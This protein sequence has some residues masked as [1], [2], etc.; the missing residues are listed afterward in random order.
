[1]L[2]YLIQDNPD[3]K[4]AI[5]EYLTENDLVFIR[6][7]INPPKKFIVCLSLKRNVNW[8]YAHFKNQ[9]N[10]S[11]NLKGRPREKSFLYDLI[12]NCHDT[13]DVDK[14]D[15]FLRDSFNTEVPI[16]FSKVT[17]DR[18]I[19]GIDVAYVERY[20]YSRIIYAPKYIE[21]YKAAAQCRLDL[22]NKLYK[23]KTATN[24]ELQLVKILVLANPHLKF[25]GKDGKLFTM[26]EAVHDVIAYSKINDSVLDLVR[27]FLL[28]Y[29]VK[30]SISVKK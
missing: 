12:S 8:M 14:L 3:V 6:E 16:S 5:S 26:S 22:H 4:K 11:W 23:H 28:L 15:Y 27:F 1:M 30:T 13:V 18:L 10:G 19:D 24:L 29:C 17:L 20:G 2:D 25:V 7:L 9:K 21:D